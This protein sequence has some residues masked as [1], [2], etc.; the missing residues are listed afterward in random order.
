MPFEEIHH[1]ADRSIRVWAE[2]LP[3]LFAEAALGFL[4]IS[5]IVLAESPSVKKEIEIHSPDP[6]SLLV[7]FLSELIFYAEQENLAF[8]QARVA[9]EGEHLSATVSGAPI[10]EIHKYIK[11]VTFHNL[12]VVKSSSGVEAEIVFDV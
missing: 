6:E 12:K 3:T 8:D 9:I 2:D 10:K 1:T 5:G 11:A 7:S 4:T